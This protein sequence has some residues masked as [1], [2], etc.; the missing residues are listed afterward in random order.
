MAAAGYA[1]LGEYLLE[2]VKLGCRVLAWVK[3][4]F[5]VF[6]IGPA[7]WILCGRFGGRIDPGCRL[8]S[9]S[10]SNSRVGRRSNCV[11]SGDF[12]SGLEFR[13]GRFGILVI[14]HGGK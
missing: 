14:A 12:F 3:L 4:R 10:R 5:R 2:A 7:Q 8:R 13:L 1:G 6:G 9:K 11:F